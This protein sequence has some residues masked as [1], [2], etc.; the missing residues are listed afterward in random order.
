MKN[1]MLFLGRLGIPSAIL[2]IL[3]TVT[4]L[5]EIQSGQVVVKAVT[6]DVSAS[7]NTNDWKPVKAGD[8]LMHGTTIKTGPNAN[9]D[10]IVD[11]NGTVLR[12]CRTASSSYPN[13]I[14]NSRPPGSSPRPV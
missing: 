12:C 1:V 13:L 2:L 6:G 4:S 8:Q 5:A 3:T 14:S 7:N 11:Y 9:A 10:L